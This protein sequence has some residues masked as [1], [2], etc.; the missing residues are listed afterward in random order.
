MTHRSATYAAAL[1]LDPAKLP[2]H[3]PII[4]HGNVRWARTQGKARVW[5]RRAFS[6]DGKGRWAGAQRKER[7]EGDGRGRKSVDEVTE[8]CCRLGIGQLALYRF[9]SEIWKRSKPEIG[10]LMA[11]LKE[12]L[13]A[14]RKKI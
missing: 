2:R 7:V 1:G 11:H 4:M 12:Y 5:R 9:S 10:F 6:W 14:E 3:I 13:L 8:E